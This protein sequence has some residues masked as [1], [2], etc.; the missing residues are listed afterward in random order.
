MRP[1]VKIA[2]GVGT[3]HLDANARVTVDDIIRAYEQQ[4]ERSRRWA[5]G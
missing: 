3:D 1:G 2:C 4:I 5:G